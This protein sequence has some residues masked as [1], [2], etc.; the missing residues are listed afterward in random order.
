[1]AAP[2]D[3]EVSSLHRLSF[4]AAAPWEVPPEVLSLDVLVTDVN[5]NAPVFSQTDYSAEIPEDQE[6]GA[7]VMK[8][9]GRGVEERGRGCKH[10]HSHTQSEGQIQTDRPIDQ[11]Y[12][13]ILLLLLL[14]TLQSSSFI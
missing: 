12:E 10:T 6:V 2:L 11:S 4:S 3:F 5:D 7:L 9:R 14:P 13:I 8:V 1:M